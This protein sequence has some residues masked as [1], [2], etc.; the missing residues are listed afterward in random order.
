M[1]WILAFWQIFIL[2]SKCHGV[3][4]CVSDIAVQTYEVPVRLEIYVEHPLL[5]TIPT[6]T[7][8]DK[9]KDYVNMPHAIS[10]FVFILSTF[11]LLLI[12]KKFIRPGKHFPLL[13]ES[14]SYRIQILMKQFAKADVVG[15]QLYKKIQMKLK[16]TTLCYPDFHILSNIL[17]TGERKESRLIL[18]SWL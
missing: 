13:L 9:D 10:V 7:E 15:W 6:Q 4:L 14:L 12:A 11:I 16:T 8:I 2:P 17:H 5:H 18:Q 3:H 1:V